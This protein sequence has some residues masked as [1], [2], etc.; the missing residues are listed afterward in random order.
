MAVR[1]NHLAFVHLTHY[2]FPARAEKHTA[3]SFAFNVLWK[4]IKF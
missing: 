2:G 1:T 3:Y 4:M